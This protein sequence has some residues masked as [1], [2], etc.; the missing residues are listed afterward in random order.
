MKKLLLIFM[1]SAGFVCI[2]IFAVDTDEYSRFYDDKDYVV[3]FNADVEYNQWIPDVT[4]T[5]YT[6]F[7]EL[8]LDFNTKSKLIIPLL[9]N[10][11]FFNPS[12]VM[13][14][15]INSSSGVAPDSSG[16]SALTVT[17]F[18]NSDLLIKGPA[19]FTLLI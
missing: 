13:T 6:K 15:V 2:S 11:L 17:S 16:N 18:I 12:Y 7:D 14:N 3:K 19:S 1:L 5:M 10:A 9:F 8:Q 4:L